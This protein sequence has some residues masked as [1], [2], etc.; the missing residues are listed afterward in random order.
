VCACERENEH[1]RKFR[2]LARRMLPSLINEGVLHTGIINVQ[3]HGHPAEKAR[4]RECVRENEYLR[5]FLVLAAQVLA[6]PVNVRTFHTEIINVL[7][8]GHPSV[9]VYV[10][11]RISGRR[12]GGRAC[13]CACVCVCLHVC[14]CVTMYGFVWYMC[15]YT[16]SLQTVAGNSGK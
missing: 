10:P 11:E 7:M 1:L 8:H 13:V 16:R 2:M 15:A 12:G 3:M 5:K 9:C 6:I 4:E 14:A